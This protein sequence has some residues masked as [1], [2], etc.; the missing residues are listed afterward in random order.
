MRS[1][2]EILAMNS[3]SP[4][5]GEPPIPPN[6][7]KTM[8]ETSEADKVAD[9]VDD[10]V[11]HW[12]RYPPEFIERIQQERDEARIKH[13]KAV[14]AAH[15]VRRDLIALAREGNA[16]QRI[17]LCALADQLQVEALVYDFDGCTTSAQGVVAHASVDGDQANDP[18]FEV[19]P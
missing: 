11:E 12:K 3:D 4:C 16:I 17:A 18:D 6:K 8:S 1:L 9:R 5:Y 2:E 19:K 14:F 13:R 10:F 15:G 7:G